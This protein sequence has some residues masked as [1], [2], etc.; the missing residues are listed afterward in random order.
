MIV[1]HNIS[2]SFQY[3]SSIFFFKTFSGPGRKTNTNLNS[4]IQQQRVVVYQKPQPTEMIH[5]QQRRQPQ[6]IRPQVKHQN[7][8]PSNINTNINN[9]TRKIIQT[10]S[11][12][13]KQVPVHSTQQQQSQ[14]QKQRININSPIKRSLISGEIAP[15]I[16]P[17]KRIKMRQGDVHATNLFITKVIISYT[18][19]KFVYYNI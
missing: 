6:Q 19:I 7:M 3:N 14:Q 18:F 8:L 16:S 5:Q 10:K 12:V 9:N 17:Q 1:R 15:R 11:I 2:S 4:S 13:R